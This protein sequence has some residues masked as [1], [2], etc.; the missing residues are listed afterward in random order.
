MPHLPGAKILRHHNAKSLGQ[1]LN[2]TQHHPVQPI[3][4]AQRRQRADPQRFS[5][6][7]SIHHGIHLLEYISNHQGERKRHQ[8][9][10]GL[11]CRQIPRLRIHR[12]PSSL[13]SGIVY[14]IKSA[15]ATEAIP[16]GLP[17]VSLALAPH[18]APISPGQVYERSLQQKTNV[19]RFLKDFHHFPEIPSKSTV[20]EK[21]TLTFAAIKARMNVGIVKS[22]VSM[23]SR[24]G[25]FFPICRPCLHFRQQH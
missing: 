17:P 5:H 15:F 21:H 16:P 4:R 19:C 12:N 1:P 23:I 7:R 20:R 13:S 24:V 9:G 6:H 3:R 8:Q 22:Y 10:Q 11:A 25:R 18:S 14:H 2:H